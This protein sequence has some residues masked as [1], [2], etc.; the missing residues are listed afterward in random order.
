MKFLALLTAL[1]VAV[2]VVAEGDEVAADGANCDQAVAVAVEQARTAAV[3]ELKHVKENLVATKRRNEELA[4]KLMTAE[5]IS[6]DIESLRKYLISANERKE[7]QIKA[8]VSINAEKVALLEE[9]EVYAVGMEKS[10]E[11]AKNLEQAAA[12]KE[13]A[14]V[15][16]KKSLEGVQAEIVTLQADLDKAQIRIVEIENVSI[17]D[18]IVTKFERIVTKIKAFL[19]KGKKQSGDEF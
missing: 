13:H 11:N 7:D 10:Q 2:V 12:D 9:A 16:I 3:Q 8:Y 1:L 5:G 18:M 19:N 14:L 6:G 4:E 17:I 15:G